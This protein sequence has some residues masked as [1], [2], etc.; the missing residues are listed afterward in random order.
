MN[1]RWR[2]RGSQLTGFSSVAR[3]EVWRLSMTKKLFAPARSPGKRRWDR[4]RSTA[5]V[6]LGTALATSLA[7][8]G[9]QRPA[10]AAAAALL[11]AIAPQPELVAPTP[12]LLDRLVVVG[13]QREIEAVAGVVARRYRVSLEATRSMVGA[14][15]RA[16]SRSGVDPLLIVAVIAVESRFNPIAQ[17]DGGA[18]GLMQII[19]HYHADKL[20]GGN[21][22]VLD[23]EINIEVGAS[24]LKEY[25][26]RGGTEV[27][28]LQLYNGASDDASNSYA[29]RVLNEKQRLKD[30]LRR[31]SAQNRA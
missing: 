26:R 25:I 31:E 28:G 23:P 11:P 6:I 20:D 2:K 27:A 14:A 1:C 12:E 18:M 4:R 5:L 7:S 19:P 17:S 29:N 15:Y 22:S 8:S 21:G 10:V 16:G 13:H 9:V 3:P 30:A 24:V